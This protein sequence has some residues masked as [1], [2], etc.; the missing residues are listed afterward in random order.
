METAR[1]FA[2]WDY[3]IFG[4]MLLFSA[5]IGIYFAFSGGRQRT[6]EEFFLGD[7]KMG[8]IPVAMS[9]VVSFV[10]AISVIGTPGEIYMYDTMFAWSLVS[11]AVSNCLV[12]RL[13]LPILFRLRIT[14]VYQYLEMRFNRTVKTACTIIFSIQTVLY[15]GIAMYTPALAINAVTGMDLW[16]CVVST[17]VICIFYTSVG[18]MKAVLWTDTLQ[19]VIILL[20]VIAVIVKG[21]IDVGGVGEVFRIG[22]QGGRIK[23]DQFSVDP[24]IRYSVW[25]MML[26]MLTTNIGKGVHQTVIQRLFS[27]G[28][29]RRA[30]QALILATIIKFIT[31][32]LCIFSGVVMYAYYVD[33]DPYTQGLV[34]SRDQIMPLMVMDLLGDMPGLP[35][36]FLSAVVSASISTLSSGVNSLAA[37]SGEDGVKVFWPNISETNYARVIKCLAVLYGVVSIGFAFIASKLG[38]GV[39]ELC[40]SLIGITSG[41][42]IGVFLLGIYMHRSNAKGALTGLIT[43]VLFVGWIKV[44]SILYPSSRGKNFLSVEGCPVPNNTESMVTGEPVT[45]ITTQITDVFSLQDDKPESRPG[46]ADLYAISFLYYSIIGLII[47]TVVGGIASKITGFTDPN[48]IDPRLKNNLTDALFWWFPESMK[49]RMRCG[50]EKVIYDDEDDTEEVKDSADFSGTNEKMKEINADENKMRFVPDDRKHSGT[51]V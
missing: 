28:S 1:H 29:R 39:L 6:A 47:C 12:I 19:T 32:G 31:V 4:V 9:V 27:C 42:I 48:T 33:C 2:I 43:S 26:G 37:I 41:S 40:L 30:A 20:G 14:S 36:L 35:G 23:L 16:A 13:F 5:A 11:Y 22:H 17:G 25:S 51:P 8:M 18:G 3:V 15:M 21:S 45:M 7:R 38:Q 10:S 24:R 49:T 46:I 50:M 44:G 34:K